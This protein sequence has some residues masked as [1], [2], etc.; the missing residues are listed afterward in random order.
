MATHEDA[1]DAAKDGGLMGGL[2]AHRVSQGEQAM[3][4]LVRSAGSS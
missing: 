3:L 2:G 4:D 1:A